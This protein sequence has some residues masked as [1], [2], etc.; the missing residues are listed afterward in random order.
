MGKGDERF[1]LASPWV[2]SGGFDGTLAGSP[3]VEEEVEPGEEKGDFDENRRR[4]RRIRF[5]AF[6]SPSRRGG[7]GSSKTSREALPYLRGLF[8]DA[9]G[10]VLCCTESSLTIRG[11]FASPTVD[12]FSWKAAA[13]AEG[14][15][16]LFPTALTALV[17]PSGGGRG[18]LATAGGS[19][20]VA[21]YPREKG[22]AAL[23]ISSLWGA[24]GKVISL[25]A[26]AWRGGGDPASSISSSSSF[27]SA[28]VVL[29]VSSHADRSVVVSG[30]GGK[31]GEGRVL[32]CGRPPSGAL[33]TALQ[34]WQPPSN[35]G[36]APLLVFTG[37]KAGRLRVF[38]Y[39]SRLTPACFATAACVPLDVVWE[40]DLMSTAIGRIVVEGSPGSMPTF[41]VF[42]DDASYQRVRLSD[43]RRSPPAFS[44][45]PP[46]AERSLRFPMD[47]SGVVAASPRVLVG[48]RGMEVSVFCRHPT[49]HA[50]RKVAAYD[51]IRAPRLMTA[52]IYEDGLGV[53]VYFAH[54][55]DGQGIEGRRYELSWN[56]PTQSIPRG[57][58]TASEE[59]WWSNT[60]TTI[61][62]GGFLPGKDFNCSVYLP[63]PF[64][65]FL[66]GN[67]DS[68]LL[69][70]GAAPPP[71]PGDETEEG[72]EGKGEGGGG[73]GGLLDAARAHL[74]RGPHRSNLLALCGMPGG[75]AEVGGSP[76]PPWAASPPSRF[77]GGGRLRGGG[78]SSRAPTNSR[79]ATRRA[80]FPPPLPRG[81][82]KNSPK[83]SHASPPRACR[84]FSPSAASVAGTSSSA[85][86]TP[87]CG[88]FISTKPPH[89]SRGNSRG[90]R[91]RSTQSRSLPSRCFR[92]KPRCGKN[93]RVKPDGCW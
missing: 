70:T 20:I 37:D 54:C 10:R 34:L 30:W 2:V 68:S 82:P 42:G 17:G 64:D 28:A 12:F 6:P 60:D 52:A 58:G 14:G 63:P 55:S 89:R 8:V 21:A 92:R 9:D 90:C 50:W 43:L 45:S 15:R 41:L 76:S 88:C 87:R 36:D 71:L 72:E 32:A 56:S 59:V 85:A 31:A 53:R 67:E 18:F 47:I 65:G 44:R 73:G 80:R 7:G 35:E 26:R 5:R 57:D 38:R 49:A 4:A 39:P 51:A 13:M 40:V 24:Y 33:P 25:I 66:H 16:G 93:P 48:R 84:V 46:S 1:P 86:A 74:F 11:G 23:S 77:W 69:S 62:A 19:L 27:A 61:L 91:M 22:D 79:R 75:I 3:I 81:F 78:A 29:L 83:D